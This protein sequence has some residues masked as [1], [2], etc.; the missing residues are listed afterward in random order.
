[1]MLKFTLLGTGTSQG[2]PMLGC[3]CRVCKSKN[4]KDNRLRTSAHIKYGDLSI[5]IDCGPDFRHQMLQN[6]IR[7]LD[8]VLLTHSHFDHIGGLDDTRPFIHI[9]QQPLNIYGNSIALSN[10]KEIFSYAFASEHY[11]GAPVF[12]LH[13]VGNDD[14]YIK[15]LK[16]TPIK[17][18]H[19]AMD[20]LGYRF[21]NIVYLTDVKHLPEEELDKIKGAELLIINALRIKKQHFS[22]LILPDVLQVIEKIN[23]KRCY[24]T[25][26]SHDMGL[27][28]E[29][30]N[31]GIKIPKN[32]HLG[33]DGLTFITHKL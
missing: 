9:Q 17:V 7:H 22:H 15:D 3:R 31:Q 5:N 24:L 30:R 18:K 29:F 23:P 12:A 11:P 1:M 26:I 2:C 27:H 10:T 16:I 4:K 21:A 13:E 14:F 20:I 28:N 33:Y 8:A 32:V 19:G 25:H 6:G